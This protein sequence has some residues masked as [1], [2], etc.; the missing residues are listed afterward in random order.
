VSLKKC[1]KIL[2][3]NQLSS[4]Y[5]VFGFPCGVWSTESNYAMSVVPDSHNP[6]I[7]QAWIGDIILYEKGG[8][9]YL[10]IRVDV[11]VGHSPTRF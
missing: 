9:I 7:L 11:H 6:C 2:S 8:D 4:F 1:H 10:Y 5:I 3:N